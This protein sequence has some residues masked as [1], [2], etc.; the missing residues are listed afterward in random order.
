ME[1]NNLPA[2]STHLRR[3]TN[4]ELIKHGLSLHAAIL[5]GALRTS[6]DYRRIHPHW[7]REVARR[8]ITEYGMNLLLVAMIQLCAAQFVAGPALLGV[9][10]ASVILLPILSVAQVFSDRLRGSCEVYTDPQGNVGMTVKVVA[11]DADGNVAQWA[12]LNHFALP[13]GK[14][15]GV[16]MRAAL[17]AEAKKCGVDLMCVAQNETVAD[18]Y[19]QE[20]PGAQ[21]SGSKRPLLCWKYRNDDAPPAVKTS[22]KK[23]DP[24]GFSSLRD[25]GQIPL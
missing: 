2:G 19:Y 18:Y 10:V 12:F 9:G 23:F 6:Q 11:L 15:E 14:R 1:R 25:S 8:F 22:K 7:R 20:H 17:H 21:M 16:R 4:A 3:A 5:W 24:F 13:I